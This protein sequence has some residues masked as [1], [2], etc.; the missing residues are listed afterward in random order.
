MALHSG[1]DQTDALEAA[2]SNSLD[3]WD[4]LHRG[5]GL[6]NE[7]LEEQA[8]RHAEMLR[9]C[10]QWTRTLPISAGIASVT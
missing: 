9:V 10:V 4:P 2:V 1:P 6:L 8:L 3:H 5:Y 7:R